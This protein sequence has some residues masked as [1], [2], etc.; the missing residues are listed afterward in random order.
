MKPWSLLFRISK[1]NVTMYMETLYDKEAALQFTIVT[2]QLQLDQLR[3]INDHQ[4]S[5]KMEKENIS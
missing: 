4:K 2:L 5:Q 3:L 1:A